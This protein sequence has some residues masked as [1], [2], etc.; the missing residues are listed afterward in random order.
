MND[1]NSN[2]RNLKIQ[3]A[4]TAG[5]DTIGDP[6]K[7]KANQIINELE[8][9]LI[10][11]NREKRQIMKHQSQKLSNGEMGNEA[12]GSEKEN[13]SNGVKKLSNSQM[14]ILSLYKD[15]SNENVGTKVK[16]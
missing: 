2:H 15:L 1:L 11:P 12:T 8:Q 16:N 5:R 6:N 4:N 9:I 3:V 14:T 13:Q 7:L 10:E